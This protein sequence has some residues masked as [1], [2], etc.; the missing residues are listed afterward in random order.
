ML[1]PILGITRTEM[2]LRFP[3]QEDVILTV[4]QSRGSVG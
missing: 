2:T 1:S 3:Y 4:L